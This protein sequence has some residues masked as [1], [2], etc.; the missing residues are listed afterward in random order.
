L[1]TTR[2]NR[3]VDKR[4]RVGDI[5]KNA[6]DGGTGFSLS[7]GAAARCLESASA[8]KRKT[9]PEWEHRRGQL[10]KKVDLSE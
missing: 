8:R 10:K 3:G 5:A 6:R 1:P 4:E 2:R 9:P 7:P